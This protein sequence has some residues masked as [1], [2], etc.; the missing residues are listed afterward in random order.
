VLLA[1][2]ARAG[3]LPPAVSVL[4]AVARHAAAAALVLVA[5]R[6]V[7]WAIPAPPVTGLRSLAALG[8]YAAIGGAAYLAALAALRA[9]ELGEAWAL[10]RRRE[11][12]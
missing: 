9:R 7:A 8:L 1:L 3:R 6:L 11:I 12:R 2:N 4:P 10:V 5:V